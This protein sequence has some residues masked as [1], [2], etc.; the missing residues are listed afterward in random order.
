M[1]EQWFLFSVEYGPQAVGHRLEMPMKLTEIT[2]ICICISKLSLHWCISI[3]AT[4][5]NVN[6]NILPLSQESVILTCVIIYYEAS[7]IHLWIDALHITE[8]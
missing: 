5:F 8:L 7:V 6:F 2:I 1:I 3:W 4:D